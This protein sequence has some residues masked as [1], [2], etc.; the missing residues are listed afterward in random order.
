MRLLW[1]V[2]AGFLLGFSV[3]TLWEWLYFRRRRITSQEI[4]EENSEETWSGRYYAEDADTPEHSPR[5]ATQAG[6]TGEVGEIDDAD[7]DGEEW[8]ATYAGPGVFLEFEDES[9]TADTSPDTPSST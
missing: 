5:T 8:E 3:S 9:P 1:F 2:F 7:A 6:Q 4:I